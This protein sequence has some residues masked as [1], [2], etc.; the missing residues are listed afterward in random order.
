MANDEA[1]AIAA[2]A[3]VAGV[4]L[5]V[6]GFA[7]G[8]GDQHHLRPDEA[9]DPPIAPGLQSGGM[10]PVLY[11]QPIT[12]HNPTVNYSGNGRKT[13]AYM[14]VKQG[15]VTVYGSGIANNEVGPAASLTTYPLVPANECQCVG[16]NPCGDQ[17][18][19]LTAYAWP[20]TDPCGMN[21]VPICG[22]PAVVGPAD[23]SIE[24]YEDS[25]ESGFPNDGVGYS[26]APTCSTPP[27]TPIRS[28]LYHNAIVFV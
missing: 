19:T 22:R 28:T 7:K 14:N 20:G 15:G 9:M 10:I 12:I 11:P 8:G 3:G 13:Y 17:S 26:P 18:P 5:L 23:V 6:I 2:L 21:S 25:S 16:T 4:G 24:I 27:R 1:L